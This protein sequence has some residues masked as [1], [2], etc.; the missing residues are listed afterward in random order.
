MVLNEN[1]YIPS[2]RELLMALRYRATWKST[3]PLRK[4]CHFYGLGR[5]MSKLIKFTTFTEDQTLSWRVYVVLVLVACY[6]CLVIYTALFF[7][8]MG[9]PI[10][11][12]PCTCFLAGPVFTVSC[13]FQSTSLYFSKP[14]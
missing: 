11:C 8:L 7:I 1:P 9:E 2:T 12:L 6:L 3:T 13:Y 14:N 10:K 5:T 4:W